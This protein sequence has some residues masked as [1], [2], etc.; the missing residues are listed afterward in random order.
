MNFSMATF[1]DGRTLSPMVDGIELLAINEAISEIVE[2]YK[3]QLMPADPFGDALHLEI[4][5]YHRCDFV[6]N[7]NCRHLANANKFGHIRRVNGM[8]GFC[9]HA[10][11]TA[12]IA[13]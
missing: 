12:R 3:A 1:Q 4:A 5:F 7:W 11:N 6:V 10:R 9:S 8:L 2:A 13:R